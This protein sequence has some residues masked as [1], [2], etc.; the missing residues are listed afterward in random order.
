MVI[1]SWEVHWMINKIGGLWSGS[2]N[3]QIMNMIAGIIWPHRVLLPN[4]Q[5]CDQFEKQ[6]SHQ[7]TFLS[8]KT[9]TVNL[10]NAQKQLMH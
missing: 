10:Q 1:G 4:N 7:H 8:K 5:N 6:P 2:S 9:T 3:C